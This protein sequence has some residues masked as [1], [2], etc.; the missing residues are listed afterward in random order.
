MIILGIDPG[1]IDMGYAIV[2]K[3]TKKVHK[4]GCWK[5]NNK[6]PIMEFLEEIIELID[7]ICD[8]FGVD[9]IVVEKMFSTGNN[10]NL[11]L[12]NVLPRLISNICT[13]R[14]IKYLIIHN[15]TIKKRVAGNGKASKIEVA[16]MVVKITGIDYDSLVAVY[17]NRV[18]NVT[19]AIS[20]ALAYEE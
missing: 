14:D 11:A 1:T 2:D 18:G 10:S 9:V 6:K 15:S 8:E 4:A 12:L 20:I 7:D 13:N 19:D 16:E 3:K 17:K 5:L